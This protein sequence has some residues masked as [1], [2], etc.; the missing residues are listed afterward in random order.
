M[1]DN[2]FIGLFKVQSNKLRISDPCYDKDSWFTGLIDDIRK[3]DWEVHVKTINNRV[4]EL[5]AYHTNIKRTTLKKSK[6]VEQDIE[7]GIDSGQCIICDDEFYPKED[8]GSY[9][10]DNSFY[11]K[12]CNL[13]HKNGGVGVLDFGVVSST[14]Y[15]DGTYTCL[16]LE[17][18]NEV[19]GVKV[20]FIEEED[21]ENL[22]SDYEND[23][24]PE[25]Y[26]E[27][28]EM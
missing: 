5:S 4:A 14:G 27:D 7:I 26:F 17:E 21:D 18:K 12:C 6:W 2:E 20:L 25:D 19:V 9:D 10:D 28:D 22:I 11:G 15:G 16:V 23:D 13:T 1:K 24:Y 3:G 8:K